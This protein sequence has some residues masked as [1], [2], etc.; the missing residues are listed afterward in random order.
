MPNIRPRIIRTFGPSSPISIEYL[1]IKKPASAK[2]IA[3]IHTGKRM[4]NCRS[5]FDC[6]LDWVD[7]SD[8][9][10]LVA[11][12]FFS[13][14]VVSLVC[15]HGFLSSTMLLFKLGV[16]FFSVIRTAYLVIYSPCYVSCKFE[17]DQQN[18]Y[19]DYIHNYKSIIVL[20]DVV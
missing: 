2:A 17:K 13:S 20:W 3:P 12:V 9:S 11:K 14:S 8:S 7:C 15:C 10:F 4:P 18:S 5:K 19:I 1:T 6:F 16:T